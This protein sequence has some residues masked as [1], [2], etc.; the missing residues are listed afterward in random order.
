MPRP[1]FLQ[2]SGEMSS[3]IR[4]FDWRRTPLGD[5]ETWPAPLAT[6][7][8]IVL[9]S[10]Q[11]MFIAWG[12]ELNLIYNDAFAPLLRARHPQALGEPCS[13][14]WADVW[15]GYGPII[16]KALGGVGSS[17]EDMLFLSY[18]S[19]E[20]EN[21][22]FTFA[23]SPL[24]CESGAVRGVL[25]IVSETT[26]R[27]LA[28]E[29]AREATR[30]LANSEER[31][32]QQAERLF[33]LFE[34]APGFVAVLE[35]PDHIVVL[36]NASYRQL[37]GHRDVVGLP[38]REARPELAGTGAFELLDRVHATGRTYVGTGASPAA[39]TAPGGR[40]RERYVDFIY[41][42]IR[43]NDGRVVGVFVQGHDVTDRVLSARKQR[44]LINEL[45]HRVM[46]NLATVQSI[47]VHTARESGDLSQ[48][49]EDFKGRIVAL[50]R[51][52][53]T[54]TQSDWSGADL[55]DLLRRELV[56]VFP[57]RVRLEGPPL[58]LDAAKAQ[59]FGLIA[60]E[61]ATNATKHGALGAPSGSVCVAWRIEDSGDRYTLE[62]E[63]SGGPPVQ[64]PA[65][66]GYGSR[67]IARL[68][69]GELAGSLEA[70][71]RP[72]GL[73]VRIAGTIA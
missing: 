25:S 65:R 1:L 27:V 2:A 39:G 56:E 50:A 46:N 62:W 48:F 73:R 45:N 30:A 15:D 9:N 22:Y 14:V 7:A 24:F 55:Q 66:Q 63:E 61:L 42:P 11:P 38:Y 51:T 43:D 16:A 26:A 18:R 32:R 19:G 54:L 59:A 70:D 53:D 41:E 71:Y 6:A 60:H 40:T 17:R 29:Q 13:V 68:A 28:T 72:E 23:T 47:A 37:I 31:F 49:M 3:R 34:K 12:P 20:G 67:L 57:G 35:G 10:P 58:R 4:A 33:A 69:K 5:P 44:L 8:S 64:P 36:T 52:H 21:A